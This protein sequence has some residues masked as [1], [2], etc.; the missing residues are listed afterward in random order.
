MRSRVSAMLG[1]SRRSKRAVAVALDTVLALACVW[2]AFGLKLDTWRLDEPGLPLATAGALLL[3]LPVFIRQGLYRAIFRYSGWGSLVAVVRAVAMYGVMYV[4]VFT[5]VGVHGVPRA[6][7]VIQPLLMLIAIGGSRLL[8]R[9]WLGNPRRGDSDDGPA[10][11][12]LIYGAGSAGRQIAS[13][14]GNSREMRATAFADDDVTLHGSTIN[15]LYVFDPKKL[16]AVIKR[17]GL[18]DVLMAIPSAS[19]TRRNEILASLRPLGL[20]IRTLPRLMDLASGRIHVG[21][22]R[23]LEIEDL[24][25]RAPV[26]PDV[27]L[28]NRNIRGR[29]VLVTGGGGSIGSELC[30]QILLLTPAKLLIL[31]SSEFALYAIHHELQA[32]L[33]KSGYPEDTVVPLLGSCQDFERMSRI[34]ETWKPHSI[35]HAAAYKHVPLV[36]HNPLEGVRNNVFG[37]FNT[38]RAAIAHGVPNFVLISTDKA[39]R[40]TNIMGASKRLAEMVLQALASDKPATI[41]GVTTPSGPFTCFSMVRFGNVLGS[42]GSVV[43]LF[44]RQIKEGGPIT[45]TDAEM[46]RYFMT[47]PEAAQLVLQAGA[48]AKGGD[49][50]VLDM[51]DPVKIYDLAVRMIEL[52]GLTMHT[53][54]VSGDIE[55]V[56]T[57]LRPG[58]KLYEELLIGD[59]PEPTQHA[60]IMTAHETHL[61]WTEMAA[62]L[63]RLSVALAD[64]DVLAVRNL[65][66][67]LVSGYTAAERIVDWIH[68]ERSQAL[69]DCRPPAPRRSEGRQH[70]A[71]RDRIDRE[72]FRAGDGQHD[73]ARLARLFEGVLAGGLAQAFDGQDHVRGAMRQAGIADPVQRA[74]DGHARDAHA[75]QRL[76]VVE[77]HQDVPAMVLVQ[78]GDQPPGHVA[79]AQDDDVAM[80]V[81]VAHRDR[82]RILPEHAVAHACQRQAQQREHRMQHQHRARDAGQPE[83]QDQHRRHQAGDR[84]GR[85]EAAEVVEGEEAPHAA[86]RREAL[87]AQQIHHDHAPADVVVV[88][89]AARRPALETEPEQVGDV[90]RREH[91]DGVGDDRQRRAAPMRA[92]HPLLDL[93]P[94]ILGTHGLDH[95]VGGN[96]RSQY[97]AQRHAQHLEVVRQGRVV[98]V[99][100][101][102]PQLLGQDDVEVLVLG[103]GHLREQLILV[104]KLQRRKIGDARPHAEHAL[105]LRR[106]ILLDVARHLR[107]RTDQAHRPAQNVDQLGQ[108]VDLRAAQQRAHARNARVAGDRQLGTAARGRVGH[109]AELE[110]AE[111]LAVAP[112]ALLAIEHRA[113]RIQ[114]D[115]DRHHQHRQGEHGQAE[116]CRADVERALQHGTKDRQWLGISP[117]V[118]CARRRTRAPRRR[119]SCACTAAGSPRARTHAGCAGTAA[120]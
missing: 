109:R 66:D 14:L 19:R 5:I 111:D 98:D 117:R 13:L 62:A 77:Q 35:Y 1:R 34:I 72:L 41:D 12:V 104:T 25:G 36:E 10:P 40:P 27:T 93:A 56:V 33:R 88:P 68:L 85:D 105:A 8:A 64:A 89:D 2:I 30:R 23:E 38:A 57:G 103:I 116:G 69:A 45:L 84:A 70:A 18:T 9:Y 49:V 73:Q 113:G 51:G 71:R 110:D 50:F 39:V 87:Q 31:E 16:P 92:R 46:T 82:A 78:A 37:T 26:S 83:Q 97:R 60:R 108:L 75:V 95:P 112:H 6:V 101:R 4:L 42:S 120:A 119:P 79:R 47:I 43:P 118:R 91:G 53:N 17:L 55:I 106:R 96:V 48:M 3:S 107:P 86:A 24:L 94:E 65:L 7:G 44:R 11:R 52:S 90:P 114:L 99:V 28:L 81:G 63:E 115:A 21:D 54:A 32:S 59:N 80:L 20:R 15:G 29:V 74:L 58:E 100:H 22:I 102:H 67:L 76:V 61:G